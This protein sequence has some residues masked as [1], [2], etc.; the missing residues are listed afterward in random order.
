MRRWDGLRVREHTST[1]RVAAPLIHK[2]LWRDFD[3]HTICRARANAMAYYPL[4]QLRLHTQQDVV[5]RL[6]H[7]AE[8]AFNVFSSKDA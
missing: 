8:A 1:C 6:L 4:W 5:A 3:A 2:L 7:S